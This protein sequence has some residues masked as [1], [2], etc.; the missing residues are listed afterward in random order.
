MT[1]NKQRP[2]QGQRHRADFAD[3][4]G[5]AAES[6]FG[7]A[8][9][10]SM[11]SLFYWATLWLLLDFHGP[12]EQ[13]ATAILAGTTGSKTRTRQMEILVLKLLALATARGRLSPELER[14]FAGAYRDLWRHFTPSN[15]KSDRDA[16]DVYLRRS[17][18]PLQMAP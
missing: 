4:F 14:H 12:A 17:G 5:R 2:A 3:S 10:Y 7:D 18:S 15:E 8:T 1:R 13:T 16:V 11:N 6:R 9:Q